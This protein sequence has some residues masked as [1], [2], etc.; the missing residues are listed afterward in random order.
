[1]TFAVGECP[2]GESHIGELPATRHY[3]I[4]IPTFHHQKLQISSKID[5]KNELMFTSVRNMPLFFQL[6]M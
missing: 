6:F 3:L 4:L 5:L 2:V 1:M